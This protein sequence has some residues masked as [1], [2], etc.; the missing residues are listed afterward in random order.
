MY[1]IALYVK[2]KK[3]N[4]RKEVLLLC[5]FIAST[6]ACAN[7]RPPCFSLW[8]TYRQVHEGPWLFDIPGTVKGIVSFTV[9]RTTEYRCSN[10]T[11][12]L[13]RTNRSIFETTQSTSENH[14][15]Q[16]RTSGLGFCDQDCEAKNVT[17]NTDH[18]NYFPGAGWT[19]WTFLGSFLYL[20]KNCDRIYWSNW[21]ET[22]N[23]KNSSKINYKRSPKDCDGD[24]ISNIYLAESSTKSKDCNHFW[25]NWVD[26]SCVAIGCNSTGQRVR[27]RQCLYENVGESAD[28]HLCSNQSAV[29]TEQC[30]TISN[31]SE[32]EFTS[33]P[34]TP[35]S[36][37]YYIIIG[38]VVVFLIF[39]I[40]T[41]T[42]CWIRKK[43]LSNQN[44]SSDSVSIEHHVYNQVQR[45]SD[46]INPQELSST[47]AIQTGSKQ[48]FAQEMQNCHQQTANQRDNSDRPNPKQLSPKRPDYLN[49]EDSLAGYEVP[50]KTGFQNNQ[51]QHVTANAQVLSEGYEIP[52]MVGFQTTLVVDAVYSQTVPDKV[53]TELSQNTNKY[54][55]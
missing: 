42:L 18:R 36:A 35:N 25:S 2:L 46:Y 9:Y 7:N 38:V 48:K 1:C 4:M 34:S 37:V 15:F 11:T 6:S 40:A 19:S 17:V 13:F 54:P 39:I 8:Q 10:T 5:L 14:N 16:F 12:A 47:P 21:I 23:C 43:R 50:S 55:L 44:S 33:S 26:E 24:E 45:S 20:H 52:E 27:R 30:N 28:F 41:L 31:S 3:P 53:E 49:L 51:I 32:C 22:S 29:M